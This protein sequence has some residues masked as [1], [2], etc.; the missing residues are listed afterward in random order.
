M[1]DNPLAGWSV[2]PAEIT[3]TGV[4][5]RRPECVLAQPSGDLWVADLGGGV[6][7]IDPGAVQEVIRPRDGGGPFAPDENPNIDGNQGFSMPNGLC[8]DAGGDFVIAN[9]GTNRIE[10]LTRDGHWSLVAD[11]VMWPDGTARPIGKANFPAFDA[12]GRLWFSVT[13]SAQA[14]RDRVRAVESDGY[15]AVVDDWSAGTPAPARVVATDLGGANEVRFSPDGRWLYVAETGADH[16]TRF[17]VEPGGRLSGREIYGPERLHGAPDGFAFDAY[18]NLWTTL[19]GKDRL[20]AITPEGDVLTIWEDGDRAVKDALVSAAT[21]GASGALDA[22]PGDG[23]A[24]RMASVTFGGPDLRTV[25][26]GSLGGTSLPTFR[27][28]VPG[29]PL[30]HWVGG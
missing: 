22:R 8:F 16:M 14:W 5:L 29:A 15:L 4:G 9:F 11:T 1:S 28:P 24:P 13:A 25:Y 23:L 26:V 10:H 12:E 6:V 30:P 2:D 17:R 20:V 19:I 3:L 27:S 18:G 7:H 21:S